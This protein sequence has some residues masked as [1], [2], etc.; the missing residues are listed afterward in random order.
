MPID[1]QTRAELLQQL[2]ATPISDDA[3]LASADQLQ[4]E[5]AEATASSL[6][7]ALEQRAWSLA[8]ERQN[9]LCSLISALVEQQEQLRA[10]LWNRYGELLAALVAALQPVLNANSE[11]PLEAPLRAELCWRLMELLEDAGKR[12]FE[13]PDWLA[14]L[15]QQLVQDGALFWLELHRSSPRTLELSLRLAQLLDPAPEWV[16]QQAQSLLQD[17]IS[18]A[19]LNNPELGVFSASCR[20]LAL[21]L[22]RWP[23]GSEQR[24]QL[25][26]ALSRME[27]SL[28]LL[29]HQQPVEAADE[30]LELVV[31]LEGEALGHQ[32]NLAPLLVGTVQELEQ[33]LQQFVAGQRASQTSLAGLASLQGS[34]Q[35]QWQQGRRLPLGA[36]G[37]LGYA[38]ASWE[39]QLGSRHPPSV[40]ADAESPILVELRRDELGALLALSRLDAG[41]DPALVELRRHHL[42]PGFWEGLDRG[43]WYGIPTALAS[44]RQLQAR[45]GFY[46]S[47]EA[48]LESLR[49][50]G[51]A[52]L[53]ALLASEGVWSSDPGCGGLWLALTQQLQGQ[54]PAMPVLQ[55]AADGQAWLRG[56]AGQEVVYVGWNWPQLQQAHRRGALFAGEPFGLRGI[57]LAESR[58]GL[59]PGRSW[60]ES[61]EECL[62]ELERLHQ[63]RAFSVVCSDGGAYR[64]PLL[65]AARSR[66]GS[67]GLAV[68][69]L[70]R[71]L[72]VDQP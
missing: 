58:R 26:L 57:A 33:A 34:L 8:V 69:D 72:E 42:N 51:Q 47:G 62:D 52:T 2:A 10:P 3:V 45:G 48:P 24:E 11:A 56:L 18:Q 55:G 17:W 63:A 71:W 50:W 23:L 67:R 32:F 31:E 7:D 21:W 38:S 41:L 9:E 5:A 46:A 39:R 44:L 6:L 54:A 15:E 64:L 43:P 16:L 37:L 30:P 70:A 13:A 36:F 19:D 1:A 25:E 49:Q 29:E 68:G 22:K 66:Y 27:L 59:R 61:L 4:L 60:S 53:A 28:Q 40:A 65:Q 12:P 35:Q 20:Q 14:V